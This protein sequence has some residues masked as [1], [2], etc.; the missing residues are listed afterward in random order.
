[1][2]LKSKRAETSE[3]SE[4]CKIINSL[5]EQKESYNCCLFTSR[6]KCENGHITEL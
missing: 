5:I 2:I 1:M 6:I 3:I 4:E